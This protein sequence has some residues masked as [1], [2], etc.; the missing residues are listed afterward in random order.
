VGLVTDSRFIIGV[1]VGAGIVYFVI[2]MVRGQM[3]A[4]QA[5]NAGR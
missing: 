5:G 2:P 4:R 3:A 1:L